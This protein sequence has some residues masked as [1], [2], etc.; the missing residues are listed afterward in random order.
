MSL[1]HFWADLLLLT[2]NV[3]IESMGGKTFGFGGGRP[4]IWHPEEDIYWG[5]ETEMLGDNSLY[6]ISTIKMGLNSTY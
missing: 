3:P 6:N 5:A 2:G 4:D 1:D